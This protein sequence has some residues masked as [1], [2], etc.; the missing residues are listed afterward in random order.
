[1]FISRKD[2]KVNIRIRRYIISQKF[3]YWFL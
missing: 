1:M 3:C 2:I